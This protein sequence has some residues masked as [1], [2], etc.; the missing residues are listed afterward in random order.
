RLICV[1]ERRF[2]GADIGLLQLLVDGEDRR[3]LR[4][5]AAFPHQ[6]RFD[7]ALLV[8]ADEYEIGLDPSLNRELAVLAAASEKQERGDH[9]ETRKTMKNVHV[10]L[11]SP[12]R[13][14]IC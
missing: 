5:R 1:R 6:Q 4:D 9:P 7:A 13:I 8:G 12:N 11:P 3:A 10:D 14:F 2:R